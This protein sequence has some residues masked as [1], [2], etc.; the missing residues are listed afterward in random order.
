MT[1][2]QISPFLALLLAALIASCTIKDEFDNSQT[3]TED[4]YQDLISVRGDKG[5]DEAQRMVDSIYGAIKDPSPVEYWRKR[6]FD[7]YLLNESRNYDRS[8]E[9]IDSLIAY[10]ESSELYPYMLN[11]LAL[12]YMY[13]GDIF[14]NY[15]FQYNR[16]YTYYARARTIGLNLDDRCL[17]S[18]YDSR[19]GGVLYR[20][21]NY[22][23]AAEYFKKSI[24]ALDDCDTPVAHFTRMQRRYDDIAISFARAGVYDSAMVY[25]NKAIDYINENRFN[26][27]VDSGFVDIALGVIYGN[28]AQTLVQLGRPNDAEPLFKRSIALNSPPDHDNNDASLSMIHLAKLYMNRG[29]LAEAGTLLEAVEANVKII[30]NPNTI[31]RW[32]DA[33]SDYHARSGNYQQALTDRLMHNA[34]QDSLNQTNLTLFNS[35]AS[36]EYNYILAQRELERLRADNEIR[37]MWLYAVSIVIS[38]FIVVMLL[39]YYAWRQ[40]RKSNVLLSQLNDQINLQKRELESTVNQ[41]REASIEKDRIM[42]MVAHDLR[43]PLG[44]IDS[45]SQLLDE[46]YVSEEGH[47]I[48]QQINFA[49]RSAQKFIGDILLLADEDRIKLDTR[50]ADI[51]ELL[52]RT[53]EMMQFR[54]KEKNQHLVY[55]GLGSAKIMKID[56]EKITRAVFNLIGNAV[57]FSPKGGEV[58]VRAVEEGG[59]VCIS[60]IDQGIGVPADMRDTIFDAFT[61]AKRSGTS[62]EKP[63]GLGLSIAKSIVTAHRGRILLNDNPDGGSIFCIELPTA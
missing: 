57:K 38:L 51:D 60:V 3:I 29:N 49:T 44:A 48:V 40:S 2:V 56:P 15:L 18:R 52:Y 33:R 35:E 11:E 34:K 53:V 22:L 17:I 7:A 63:Y 47:E 20:R 26:I 5:I 25:H 37:S 13:K 12:T 24:I 45:L 43:N 30:P 62:G 6:N 10:I 19:F 41:L 46:D 42:W 28:M 27:D 31:T 39:T 55:Q 14:N 54:A 61:K 8:L 58:V 59:N 1:K 21:Q 23:D 36:N 16:A 32:L 50:E 9:V 4:D